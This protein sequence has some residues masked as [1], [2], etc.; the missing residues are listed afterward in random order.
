MAN[1][2]KEITIHSSAAEYLTYVA[3][4]GSNSDSFEM[5]YED[6]NI[7]LTQKMMATLYDVSVS[8]I[9]Q[10][11]KRIFEDNELVE[12][13]VIKKYLITASDG[14]SYSTKHYNLQA[15]IAVGFK[16]NNERAVRF[17]KWAGQ[18]VKDYTIQ[19]WTMDK[20]RLKKGHMFTDEYFE[21]Q[22]ENIREIR[23]SE[24][25]FYQKVTDLYA[26]AFDYDKDAKTTRQFFKMVQ[27][28]MH[29][30]VH[31]H[32]AA[33]LIVERANAEKEHMGLTTWES[34][35]DGKIVKADV[36]VAKNYLS[37][38][39]MSY[40]QRIVS[41][42]LDY[43]ELQAERRIPMSMEDWAKRLDGFLEFNGNELLM[44]PGKVSAEQAKLHA[45][46]EFEKYR[47]VQ[48]RLFMSDYDKYLLELEHQA[49]QSET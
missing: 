49:E 36:T 27:N 13:S 11:L 25:K 5:R 15:I 37:E 42:Y 16:I 39:E 20:E 21:R 2:N 3:S 4:T 6:E 23:L 28:K 26:T 35:P 31:R 32:T 30:A 38:K 41:L 18:I 1:K 45:E 46:T 14:K 19:G 7:W 12:E 29:W 44:G 34:A 10:H 24:R 43:A 47:I 22:L 8:A 48:D 17:R 9:N 40:L 33:E